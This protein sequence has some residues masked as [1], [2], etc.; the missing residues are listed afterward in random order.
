MPPAAPTQAPATSADALN[1]MTQAQSQMQSPDQLLSGQEQQ[2]GVPQAQQQVSGL[3]QAIA[4]TTNLLNN[5][6]PSVEGRTQNS[7]VTSA[8]AN[9]QIQNESAPIAKTLSD[10][11]QKEAVASADY[12]D[13]LGQAG[14]K[15]QLLQAGQEQKLSFLKN[16]YDALFGK[17]QADA[18]AK[19]D[20]AAQSLEQQKLAEQI[21]ESNQNNSL[22]QQKLASSTQSAAAKAQSDL[23]SKYNV[24]QGSQGQYM[25]SDNNGV[26]IT[27]A[28]YAQAKGLGSGDILNMLR[29]GTTYD[30]NIY[31]K[32][33]NLSG[34]Q[35][36]AALNGYKVYGQF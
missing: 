36:A 12:K 30:Q 6:A 17:E 10:Q 33:H 29:Y 1:Q 14:Q 25:F 34:D 18:K 19:A 5:V 21:R 22:E 27:M 35:L 16:V 20:A 4:N 24:K 32:V 31:N 23:L 9:R 2:M 11:T 26:P 13:L 8:Q 7:L 28:Q 15:A 3:R